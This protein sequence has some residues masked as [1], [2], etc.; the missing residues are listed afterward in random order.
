ME[1]SSDRATLKPTL[2]RH[3]IITGGGRNVDGG[4][5][6]REL[7]TPPDGALRAGQDP[8]PASGSPA[9]A[10]GSPGGGSPLDKYLEIV[11]PLSGSEVDIP[12]LP[13]LR[14]GAALH[15]FLRG[16]T[17]LKSVKDCGSGLAFG[18]SAAVVRYDGKR[19]GYSGVCRCRSPWSC[20]SC[21]PIKAA[22]VR[23]D[24]M[25]AQAVHVE[26]GGLL[27]FSTHTL[28]HGARDPLAKSLASLQAVWRSVTHGRALRGRVREVGSHRVVEVTHGAHGWHAHYHVLW[29]FPADWTLDQGEDFLGAFEAAWVNA[30][31]N[32]HLRVSAAA[33]HF[34]VPKGNNGALVLAEYLTKQSRIF[35]WESTG[36]LT[37][38]GRQGSRTQWQLLVDASLG[39]GAAL[40]LWREYETATKGRHMTRWSDGLLA[41]LGCE[42]S[43]ADVVFDFDGLD[44]LVLPGDVYPSLVRIGGESELLRLLESGGWESGVRACIDWLE[45]RGYTWE[46]PSWVYG[47]GLDGTPE[48]LSVVRQYG[49]AG[50]VSAWVAPDWTLGNF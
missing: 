41:S 14:Q 23:G 16:V 45:A 27:G 5:Q 29:F 47:L 32:R 34:R 43:D 31:R 35:A 17:G 50:A 24:L 30:G 22:G 40:D 6:G 10:K 25:R 3:P 9:I 13:S 12:A 42:M 2:Q 7:D 49:L 28:G 46:V 21:S 38:Q 8:H 26:R 1:N 18:A 11:G 36:S 48:Q 20:P 37:K 44:V 4:P 19:A 33:Q 39:D 15:R